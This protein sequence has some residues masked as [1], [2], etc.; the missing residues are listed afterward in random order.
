MTIYMTGVRKV[1]SRHMSCSRLNN[2][3]T[4]TVQSHQWPWGGSWSLKS[5]LVRKEIETVKRHYCL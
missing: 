1:I 2:Y 5:F 4:S 3:T